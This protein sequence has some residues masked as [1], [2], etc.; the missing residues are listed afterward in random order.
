MRPPYRVRP[1]A[2]WAILR[3]ASEEEI[4]LFPKIRAELARFHVRSVPRPPNPHGSV[5]NKKRAIG[6]QRGGPPINR[7][8]VKVDHFSVLKSAP[9]G[10]FRQAAPSFA[11][12]RYMAGVVGL[13]PTRRITRRIQISE[14]VDEKDAQSPPTS[15]LAKLGTGV[16]N[17]DASRSTVLSDHVT[18]N[19]R[20]RDRGECF[21]D[22]I[23]D[24]GMQGRRNAVVSHYTE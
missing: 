10:R 6:R 8:D 14:V 16:P 20:F 24:H 7:R 3:I 11:L 9:K 21:E 4:Q 13:M 23:L 19:L 17:E 12:V 18:R 15:N 1:G 22:A 5:A 2:L